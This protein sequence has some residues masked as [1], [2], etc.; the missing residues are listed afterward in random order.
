MCIGS[1]I[2]AGLCLYCRFSR[3]VLLKKTKKK[4]KNGSSLCTQH[5]GWKHHS[6][7]NSPSTDVSPC[8]A[9]TIGS[10]RTNFLQ[11]KIEILIRVIIT[12]SFLI[13]FL[14]VD[15]FLGLYTGDNFSHPPRLFPLPP[16]PCTS[17]FFSTLEIAPS[18]LQNAV[19]SASPCFCY[20][21]IPT[22]PRHPTLPPL[23]LSLSPSLPLCLSA[24]LGSR[25][26]AGL[27]P[28]CGR[29]Q[30]STARLAPALQ[31]TRPCRNVALAA[32][33]RGNATGRR[34]HILECLSF[35]YLFSIFCL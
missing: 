11:N 17:P 21:S 10:P 24:S 29:S 15:V 16:S 20:R 14:C 30:S 8:K 2:S 28:L 25:N 22:S 27:P 12:V 4:S 19:R 18:I 33:L 1:E 23:C 5:G 9:F 34:R 26:D 13:Y 3:G 35:I 32:R 31:D 6:P 7:V